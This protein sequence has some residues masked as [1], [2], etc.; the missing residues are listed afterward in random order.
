MSMLKYYLILLVFIAGCSGPKVK[1]LTLDY[2]KFLGPAR[3]AYQIAEEKPALLKQ[4]HCYCGCDREMGHQN[5]FDCFRDEHSSHCPICMGEA[6][7]ADRL[8]SEGKTV[9]Q[10]KQ[11]LKEHY[12]QE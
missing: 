3:E 5:L 11:Y 8:D 2:H 6:I 9:D 7:V 10:I 4:L 1:S 12:K